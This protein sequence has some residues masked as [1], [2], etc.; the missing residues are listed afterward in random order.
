MTSL[1]TSSRQADL[2]NIVTKTDLAVTKADLEARIART[3]GEIIK[4]AAGL[5]GFQT[6]AI[7]GAV[8]ALVRFLHT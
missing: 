5:I 4:W 3:E 8:V 2:A 1:V 7:L 6:L